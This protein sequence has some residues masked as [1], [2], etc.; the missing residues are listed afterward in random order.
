MRTAEQRVVEVL[1]KWAEAAN[2]GD[3]DA[4]GASFR[5]TRVSDARMAA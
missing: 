5:N 3:T 1:R 4:D 2:V